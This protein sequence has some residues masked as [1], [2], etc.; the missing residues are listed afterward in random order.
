MKRAF[1]CLIIT[2]LLA[3]SVCASTLGDCIT[4]M[5]FD[6]AS[7]R[8][9]RYSDDGTKE[10]SAPEGWMSIINAS[11]ATLSDSVTVEIKGFDDLAF[12]LNKVSEYDVSITAKGNVIDDE[13]YIIYD[14]IYNS[15]YKLLRVSEGTAAIN[16]LT[17]E[18]RYYYSLLKKQA[19]IINSKYSQPYDKEKAIHDYIVDTFAYTDGE[20]IKDSH[21]VVGLMKDG[22]GVCEAYAVL[23]AIL[24][25]MTGI[26]NTIVTGT[27]DGVDHMWNMV[28]LDGEYYHV[29][30]TS[31]DPLPDVKGR[32]RYGY[33]N[34]T[35][36][37]ILKDHVID[38]GFPV[39]GGTKYNYHRLNGY[40]VHSADELKSLISERIAAGDKRIS[41][42]TEGYALGSSEDVVNAMPESYS[43]RMWIVGDYG[44]DGV[45]YVDIS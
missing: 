3:E 22:N 37:E 20:I 25:N 29:D 9:S 44:T 15:N 40:V 6:M 45:Y 13:A 5:R 21:Q 30:V 17:L 7:V 11:K 16:K 2:I 33:F 10:T 24:C 1:F 43:G 12:D 41:F 32:I 28:K 34:I 14:F 36:K 38:E 31:D 39:C 26:E 27:L 42:L 23:F 18:E 19:D 8:G 35:D 4:A